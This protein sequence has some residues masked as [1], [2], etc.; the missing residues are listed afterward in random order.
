[1]RLVHSPPVVFAPQG[2]RPV[3][4][5]PAAFGS[6]FGHLVQPVRVGRAVL[7]LRMVGLEIALVVRAALVPVCV[8]GLYW[9]ESVV[10]SPMN[11]LE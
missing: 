10:Q 2:G 7:V 4:S 9:T 8:I 11:A 3:C 5:A 1:M 6:R